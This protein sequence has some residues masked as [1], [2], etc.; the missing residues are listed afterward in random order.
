MHSKGERVKQARNVMLCALWTV[1]GG[2]T[3]FVLAHLI[4]AQ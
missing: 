2:L 3:G 4:M 1:W